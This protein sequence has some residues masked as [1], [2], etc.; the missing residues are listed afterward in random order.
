MVAGSSKKDIA[1]NIDLA[2]SVEITEWAAWELVIRGWVEL[3][4]RLEFLV[5][6]S[7]RGSRLR[8]MIWK[9]SYAARTFLPLRDDL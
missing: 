9:K 3:T 6:E 5:T 1:C 8:P 2:S 7:K 4:W